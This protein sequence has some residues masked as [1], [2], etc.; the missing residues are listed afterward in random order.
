MGLLVLKSY[1]N[2]LTSAAATCLWQEWMIWYQ[3]EEPSASTGAFGK[4]GP[5]FVRGVYAYTLRPY[6]FSAHSLKQRRPKSRSKRF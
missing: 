1:L 4:I 3:G 6:A 5:V 2:L